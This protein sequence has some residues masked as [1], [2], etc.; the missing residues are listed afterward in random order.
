MLLSGDHTLSSTAGDHP[1]PLPTT[2]PPPCLFSTPILQ[3]STFPSS[4]PCR[5]P[6]RTTIASSP[7]PFPSFFWPLCL[8]PFPHLQGLSSLP[9][10][11]AHSWRPCSCAERVQ[12]LK[13]SCLRETGPP[14]PAPAREVDVA[15]GP[16]E[17]A[18][19]SVSIP[20]PHPLPL[21]PSPRLQRGFPCLSVPGGEHEC[22]CAL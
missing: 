1:G 9:F 7:L 14:E 16:L 18:L 4:E 21:P 13:C 17:P 10:L 8:P 3:R 2:P 12:R 11:P 5:E 20:I 22:D 15:Q 6:V 19:I